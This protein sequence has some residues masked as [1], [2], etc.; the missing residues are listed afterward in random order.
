MKN[1][2]KTLKIRKIDYTTS[3]ELRQEKQ[4]LILSR[5]SLS[6][7]SKSLSNFQV[8]KQEENLPNG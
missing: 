8:A 3:D 2:A 4:Y 5:K 6:K 1:I 7:F